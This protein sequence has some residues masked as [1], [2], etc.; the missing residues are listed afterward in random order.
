MIMSSSFYRGLVGLVIIVFAALPAAAQTSGE[1]APVRLVQPK[2][3]RAG[4]T[5]DSDIAFIKQLMARGAYMTAAG[6][7]EDEYN[8]SPGNREIINLLLNCYLEL[9]AYPKAG[10][11]L[12]RELEKNPDDFDYNEQL[13]VIHIRTGADSLVTRQLDSMLALFPD[14]EQVYE[15]LAGKLTENGLV[16][17]AIEVIRR[18]REHFEDPYLFGIELA[19]LLE[20]KREYY[21]SVMEYFRALHHDTTLA[22]GVDHRLGNLIRYPGASDDVIAALRDLL[23]TL[24]NNK[25]AL[26]ILQEA[27]VQ[28]EMFEEAFDLTIALDSINGSGGKDIY[29]YLQR[30]R[31]RQLHDQVI[32]MAE[33]IDSTFGDASMISEYRFFCA[34]ALTGL[35]RFDEALDVLRQ[36]YETFP[37]ARD[38]ARALLQAGQI[39][40]Y[41]LARHDTARRYYDSVISQFN[42]QPINYL[43]RV[44]IAELLIVQGR[45]DSARVNLEKLSE[46]NVSDAQAEKIAYQLAMIHF[47]K[48]EFE[49]AD[50]AFRTLV[51]RYPRGFYVNDALINSLIIGEAALGFEEALARYAE[52]LFYEVRL[53]PDS[54]VARYSQIMDMDATPLGGLAAYQLAD[55]YRENGDISEALA[56]VEKTSEEYPEDYFRPYCLKLQADI[57]FE[58]KGEAEEAA[59]IYRRLLEEFGDYPFVGE[60]R[61][62]LQRIQASLPAS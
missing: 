8:V 32:R 1:D 29:I 58:D 4:Q 26:G 50:E 54:V 45:L 34:E 52:A 28:E 37:M 9:K 15:R 51:V 39:Y 62:S 40:R 48:K 60:V 18:G 47:Y 53:M 44:E 10:M 31:E 11:L 55:F 21:N 27:Y 22:G 56:V 36:I 5:A 25:Y 2:Q 24:P 61:Q 6:L 42:I 35:S 13:L 43:T 3:E 33:Y 30:C 12:N 7:L 17:L 49:K 23:D 57:Y 19:T 38:K 16:D 14:R 41:H 59:S 46:R 20:I